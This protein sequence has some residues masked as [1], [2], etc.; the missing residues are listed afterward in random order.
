MRLWDHK[1]FIKDFY[2]DETQFAKSIENEKERVRRLCLKGKE[3]FSDYETD[4]V[5]Q[6][7]ETIVDF[8]VTSGDLPVLQK[9]KHIKNQWQLLMGPENERLCPS[10]GKLSKRAA[11]CGNAAASCERENSRI[12]RYKSKLSSSM[13]IEMM[14]A[15]SRVAR[16]GP[17]LHLFDAGES[18]KYWIIKGHRHALKSS[19]SKGS[20]VIE[21][22]KREKE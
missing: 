21:R 15:R 9:P 8:F 17:P 20:M 19:S 11:M 13:G 3:F 12:E 2:Q 7:F 16:N 1:I 22:K 5:I 14:T 4:V 6:E 18:V 10:L